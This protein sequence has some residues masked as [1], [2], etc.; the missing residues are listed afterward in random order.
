[1]KASIA[2]SNAR[3][4]YQKGS[5]IRKNSDW[6]RAS[7]ISIAILPEK[8]EF[9]PKEFVR[10]H[11]E[12]CSDES[13]KHNGI[14]LSFICREKSLFTKQVGKHSYTYSEER[15]HIDDQTLIRDPGTTGPGDIREPFEFEI[16]LETPTSYEGPCGTIRY[17]LIAQIE[18]SWARDPKDEKILI[19]HVPEEAE[20]AN[21]RTDGVDHDG[22]P[23]LE[24]QI[25]EDSIYLGNTIRGNY[26]ILQ[27]PKMRG[28]RVD[29][30]AKEETRAS[31][32][33]ETRETELY[34]TFTEEERILKNSWMPFE[35]PTD[36]MMPTPFE[37]ELITVETLVRV[38]IDV[39]WRFDKVVDIPVR[40]FYG[41]GVA[42]SEKNDQWDEFSF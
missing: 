32:R 21:A 17:L 30:I 24:V 2:P 6:E 3:T 1:M 38:A 23:I 16:P 9:K 25:D 26:R 31:G 8:T 18:R 33:S 12:I 14:H 39:P 34:T 7:L 42:S 15:L 4:K 29:L 35:I 10:G 5:R 36:E 27:E 20:P 37:S 41:S 13:F 40:L 11:V 19:V 28:V 22:Y